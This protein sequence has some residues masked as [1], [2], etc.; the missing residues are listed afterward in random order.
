MTSSPRRSATPTPAPSPP[1]RSPTPTPA[2]P[3]P[4]RSPTPPRRTP[5]PASSPPHRSPTPPHSL[6]S[7]ALQR[8]LRSRRQRRPKK[9]VI[10]QE[11]LPEKTDEQI[12]AEED[13]KVKDFFI[14]I[15]N[16]RQAKLKEKTY[17]LHTMRSAEAEGQS[18]QEKEA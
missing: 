12:T 3:P 13:K 10:S 1:Q 18:S 15:Q 2:P 7:D 8:R 6:H 17:F 9:R 11:I 14:D 4:Q 5:T 16:Q